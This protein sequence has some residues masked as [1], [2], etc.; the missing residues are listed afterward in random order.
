MNRTAKVANAQRSSTPG[1]SVSSQSSGRTKTFGFGCGWLSSLL[2]HSLQTSAERGLMWSLGQSRTLKLAP[3]KLQNV[4]FPGLVRW[5]FRQSFI[6]PHRKA[7]ASSPGGRNHTAD[8][9]PLRLID[10]KVESQK[11]LSVYLEISERI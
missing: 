10:S 8:Q 4:G 5:Q 2:P 7:W 11:I 1:A 9:K 3:Q 6:K